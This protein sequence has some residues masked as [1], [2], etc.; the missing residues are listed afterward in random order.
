M[1]YIVHGIF[2]A[3][4]LEWIAIPFSRGSF[5]SKN[6]TQVF[7]IAGGFFTVWTTKEAC[8]A[9]THTHTH[10]YF[11]LCLVASGILFLQPGV[12]RGPL[13]VRMLSPSHWTTRE[14]LGIHIIESK[15]VSCSVVSNSLQP[16]DYTL[17]GSSV[18]GILQ[19][20]ILEWIAIPFSRESSQPRDWIPVSCIAGGFFT[21]WASRKAHT[22]D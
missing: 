22:Y 15:N 1:D 3:G 8:S 10:I 18:H 5:Q 12:E 17:P 21:V 11:W 7:P 14:L 13:A 6:Q 4:I 16:H 2:Q 20:G 19:A 9:Y